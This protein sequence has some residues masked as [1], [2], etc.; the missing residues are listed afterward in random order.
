MNMQDGIEDKVVVVA[1]AS[2]DTSRY[3]YKIHRDIKA[4]GF[5]TYLINP[6]V[7]DVDG[8]AL[9]KDLAAVGGPIDA[10]VLVVAPPLTLPLVK[11]A[12]EAKV[13]EIWFQPGTFNREA[14]DLAKAAGIDAHDSCFMLEHSIW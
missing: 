1:G 9:I 5:K 6:R 10:L 7:S 2:E 14:F 8:A 4:Y 13:K 11:Q 12:V 3:W